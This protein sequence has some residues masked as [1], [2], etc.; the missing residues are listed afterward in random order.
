M[1]HVKLDLYRNGVTSFSSTNILGVAILLVL[2]L[3]GVIFVSA[4]VCVDDGDPPY[5]WVE[6][7]EQFQS[8][9]GVQSSVVVKPVMS[10]A[11]I[12]WVHEMDRF[13][14]GFVGEEGQHT[15]LSRPDV[16]TMVCYS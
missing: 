11:R 15:S 3:F 8:G 10:S 1:Y 7:W 13:L 4:R 16:R 12:Y 2:R 9:Q 6:M 14:R 5:A